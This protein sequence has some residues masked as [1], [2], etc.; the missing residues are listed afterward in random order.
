MEISGTTEFLG[1]GITTEMRFHETSVS[2]AVV[3][4]FLH[5]H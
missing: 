5:R 2:L 3:D 1:F 4:W